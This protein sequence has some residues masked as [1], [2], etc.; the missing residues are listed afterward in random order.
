M[1][2][3]RTAEFYL[4]N[5]KIDHQIGKY[6]GS[7]D[8]PRS[9]VQQAKQTNGQEYKSYRQRTYDRQRGAR[10]VDISSIKSNGSSDGNNEPS[11]SVLGNINRS[12]KRN[13]TK[14]DDAD[15]IEEQENGDKNENESEN[16][17]DEPPESQDNSNENE[18]DPEQNENDDTGNGEPPE[19]GGNEEN[20]DA[21]EN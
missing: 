13:S 14:E 1:Q 16:T 18:R 6:N 15:T 9:F 19:N 2:K 8:A 11:K 4:H 7:L 17:N 20:D 12:L 21:G 5:Q 10:L 3:G